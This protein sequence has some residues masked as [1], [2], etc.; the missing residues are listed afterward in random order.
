VIPADLIG[1]PFRNRFVL[2]RFAD[3][4][5]I[6][7]LSSGTYTRMNASAAEICSILGESDDLASARSRI[8]ARVIPH[9]ERIDSALMT[10]A[11]GLTRMGPRKQAELPFCYT[12]ADS[13]YVLA[14]GGVPAVRVASDGR[15]I[16]LLV[17]PASRAEIFQYLRTLAPKL[18]FLQSRLVLHG[19]ASETPGGIRIISGESGAGKTT[20]ARA[21]DAAGTRLFSE[22][23]IVIASTAPVRVYV[24]GERAIN[25]W[26]ASS[27]EKLARGPA[28][29]L[30]VSELSQ[31]IGEATERVREIW[32]ISASR[33]RAGDAPIAPA[34]LGETD[35]ALAVMT[36]LFLGGVAES[37]WRQ[38]MSTTSQIALGVPVYDVAMPAGLDRLAEAARAYSENSAS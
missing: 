12:P 30:D 31:S 19:A 33:R 20:T 35:A 1:A 2:R 18:L 5:V 29:E 9:P 23:M 13:G 4:G 15:T 11:D 32:F 28:A 38:F 22:D 37:G 36:S 3:G 25:D 24:N 7:D 6:V 16:A 27:A 17:Q 8:E 26:A 21:F 10:I 14:N 34:R